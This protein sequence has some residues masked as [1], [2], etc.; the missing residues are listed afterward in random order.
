MFDLIEFKVIN[1][2]GQKLNVI[3]DVLKVAGLN[4]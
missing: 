3:L 1:G 4:D 2:S